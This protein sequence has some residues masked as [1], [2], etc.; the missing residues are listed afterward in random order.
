MSGIASLRS[1]GATFSLANSPQEVRSHAEEMFDLAN[2]HGFAFWQAI[3]TDWLGL[4]SAAI[5][6]ADDG[7]ELLTKALSS[8]RAA[9]AVVCT[10]MWLTHLADAH[11]RL[12]LWR[13]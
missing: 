3:A 4:A 1:T 6:Q 10:P 7:V 12:G 11:G 9:G 13:A 2:V 5:G 8:I